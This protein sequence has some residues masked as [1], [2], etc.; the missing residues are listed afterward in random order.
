[1]EHIEK[2][3]CS[4]Y[5]V[6]AVVGGQLSSCLIYGQR[7]WLVNGHVVESRQIAYT[8]SVAAS[9]LAIIV[10]A[11]FLD[12]IPIGIASRRARMW[13]ASFICAYQSGPANIPH[14][15]TP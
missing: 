5:L 12:A 1:M 9:V 10:G 7:F 3:K 14:N 15:T 13:F 4:R 6:S 8:C 2:N 11:A